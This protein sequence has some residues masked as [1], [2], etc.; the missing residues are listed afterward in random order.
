MSVA[1]VACQWT[2]ATSKKQ[3]KNYLKKKGCSNR[4]V[5]I[6]PDG[7]I[8]LQSIAAEEPVRASE[9]F[10]LIKE[11]ASLIIDTEFYRDICRQIQGEQF[12][13][14]VILGI[15]GF[16]NKTAQLQAALA[17]CLRRDYISS[18][19]TA[20]IFDPIF[21]AEE[22]NLCRLLGFDPIEMNTKGK[23]TCN[24]RTLFLMPHCPYRLYCNVLWSNW[25]A[26]L[27]HCCI[28][29]NRYESKCFIRMIF[30]LNGV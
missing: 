15:G 30:F 8:S 27:A 4:T 22:I 20:E 2:T 23:I 24:N 3:R 12:E 16:H 5:G 29:G 11:Y 6:I 10:S 18:L 19:G 13:S 26:A 1:D 14:F 17:V 9:T 7:I 25:G 21:K 28:I